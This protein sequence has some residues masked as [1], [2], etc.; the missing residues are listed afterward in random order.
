MTVDK[1]LFKNNGVAF[2]RVKAFA[3][4]FDVTPPP[5]KYLNVKVVFEGAIP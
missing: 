4:T 5:V 1:L 3:P 2:N